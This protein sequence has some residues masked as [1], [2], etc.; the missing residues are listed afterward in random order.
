MNIGRAQ[1][2][3]DW[4]A[5]AIH[6]EVTLRPRLTAVGRVRTNLVAPALGGQAGRVERAPAPVDQPGAAEQIEQ[7]VMK[8]LPKARLFAN[9]AAAASTSCRSRSPSPAEASARGCQTSAEEYR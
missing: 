7:L 9:P 6:H 8:G 1:Q 3:D 5:L 4:Y 2:H